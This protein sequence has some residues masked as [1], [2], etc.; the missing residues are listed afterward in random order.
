MVKWLLHGCVLSFHHLF[1][2]L[3]ILLLLIP[4]YFRY[5]L[6]IF[7]IIIDNFTDILVLPTVACGLQCHSTTPVHFFI[8]INTLDF[9]YTRRT[10]DSNTI[11]VSMHTIDLCWLRFKFLCWLELM[12]SGHPKFI[13]YRRVLSNFYQN[14]PSLEIFLRQVSAAT[15]KLHSKV[16]LDGDIERHALVPPFP[17]INRCIITVILLQWQ[18]DQVET[19]Q[20]HA[21]WS[22]LAFQ[23]LLILQQGRTDVEWHHVIDYD[24]T[25]REKQWTQTQT[26]PRYMDFTH[27]IC[28]IYCQS[29]SCNEKLLF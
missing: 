19:V 1:G 5:I 26:R 24:M 9:Y 20:P 23:M 4:I 16:R 14:L 8:W 3:P 22:L 17:M 10:Y 27:F 28:Y 11:L 13:V 6:H 15:S 21:E 7:L 12:A 25:G 18:R 2:E 29:P